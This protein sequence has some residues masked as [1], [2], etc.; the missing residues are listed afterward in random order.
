[1]TQIFFSEDENEWIH[2][3]SSNGLTCK[4]KEYKLWALQ[5]L[6]NRYIHNATEGENSAINSSSHKQHVKDSG[7]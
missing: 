5:A 6:N 2:K 4:K 7:P 3:K 1:M